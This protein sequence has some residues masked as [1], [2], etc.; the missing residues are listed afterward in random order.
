MKFKKK[1]LKK[2]SLFLIQI[3]LIQANVHN[4]VTGVS[5]K[6]Q[7]NKVWP[8]MFINIDYTYQQTWKHCL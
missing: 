6:Q 5:E 7:I 8:N 4:Q 3:L 2:L 1:I